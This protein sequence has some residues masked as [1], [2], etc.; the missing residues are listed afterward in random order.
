MK[1]RLDRE[2]VIRGHSY[3]TAIANVLFPTMAIF[4]VIARENGRFAV[5]VPEDISATLDIIRR[6]TIVEGL[7]ICRQLLSCSNPPLSFG[8]EIFSQAFGHNSRS[9]QFG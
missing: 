3:R 4:H 2:Y 9:S 5:L 6:E 7:F 1:L 8:F